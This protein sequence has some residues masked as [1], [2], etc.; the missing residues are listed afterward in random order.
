MKKIIFSKITQVINVLLLHTQ[1]KI[2]GVNYGKKLRGNVCTLKNVGT[3]KI[4]NN[5]LLNSHPDGEI[6]KTGLLTHLKS[7]I[8]QIGDNC[9]LNGTIVHARTSVIIG[10]NSMFGPGVVILDN[11][12]HNPSIDP[13]IRRTGPITSSPV[14]IGRNVW[15]GMHSIIMKGVHI[16]DN[17]IVAA[18]SVLTKDIPSNQLFGGNPAH[19]VREL[20]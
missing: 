3:I 8:I 10:D 16:G 9:W 1:L 18:G 20:E 14:I 5:V 13:T 15:I 2:H 17:S 12:S 11:D 7:S 6:Y 19:F 4:G